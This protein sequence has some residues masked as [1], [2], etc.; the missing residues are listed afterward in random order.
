M[1]L[2]LLQLACQ[3]VGSISVQ[4]PDTDATGV[5]TADSEAATQHQPGEWPAILVN[6]FQASN[7]TT[8]E[9]GSGGYPDWIELFNASDSLVNLAGWTLSDNLDNPEDHRLE[10]LAL[11]PGERALLWADNNQSLGPDHLDFSLDRGGGVILL[12]APDGTIVEQV[13]YPQ[14]G[15][16]LA[17][18]RSP[19]GG[20]TWHL[21]LDATPGVANVDVGLSPPDPDPPDG[22]CTLDDDLPN[23]WFL[24]GETVAFTV[25]CEGELGLDDAELKLLEIPDEGEFD[26]SALTFF[27]ETGPASGGRHDLVFSLRAAGATDRVPAAELITFWVADNPGA[28][29]PETYT[30]EWGL[31]VFHISHQGSLTESYVS[32]TTVYLGQ[33]YP[34]EIKIRGAASAGYPKNSWTVKYP[35]PEIDVAGWDRSR[36]H[37]VFLTT[38]DDNS[39]VRQKLIYDLWEAMAEHAGEERLT[40]RTFFA[41]VYLQGSYHG[42]Y[43][44]MDHVDNEFV[45][46]F[47]LE[48]DGNLY[49]SINHDAN[50]EFTDY[51][52]NIKST[53]HLGY[54][55]K[56]GEPSDDFSDLD[57]LV[58]WSAPASANTILAEAEEWF[59]LGEFQD[60]FLLV[61]YSLSEDSAG[62]NAYL[63][64]DPSQPTRFRYVPWDFNHAWGQNWYTARVGSDALNDYFSVNRLFWA[65]QTDSAGAEA[66]WDRFRDLRA[67]GPLSNDW[68]R[69]TLDDYYALIHPSAKRDWERWTYDYHHEW[70]APYRQSDWTTYAEE[71]DYLYDWL[72][73]RADLFED[74]VP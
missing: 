12:S 10:D 39:Y 28:S 3:G 15:T 4:S 43:V 37:L 2:C 34:H 35:D 1:V 36:D 51:Y 46:H 32:G 52:G 73:E 17:A 33:S 27:W 47:G 40:P 7:E 8:V 50:F 55:K 30:E 61:Y 69:G 48:R 49:K 74:L 5:D 66:L 71:K 38:F 25:T 18:A 58:A 14:Q 67:T 65:M 31:P 24:E 44:V 54:E 13:D 62:K 6:E 59:P 21:T 22:T 42:L 26:G 63:Y 45:D 11:E 72:D 16:D 56:E 53:L 64:N 19:D 29:D 70:W 23:P 68:L 9:D 20:E 60:W 57:S 41:V